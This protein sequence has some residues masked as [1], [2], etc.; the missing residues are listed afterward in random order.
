[1]D[2]LMKLVE[3]MKLKIQQEKNIMKCM[4]VKIAH[5]KFVFHKKNTKDIEN[6]M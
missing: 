2:M 6:I 4:N 1:M 5:Q 3:I